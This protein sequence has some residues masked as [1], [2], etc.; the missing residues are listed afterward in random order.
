MRLFV[1]VNLPA[2]ERERVQH[3]TS[4]LRESTLPVQWVAPDAYHLTLKFLGEVV[5]QRASEVGR[6]VSEAATY[7]QSFPLRLRAAGAFPSVR[8]PSV[9]WI[10]VERSESLAA[11]QQSVERTLAPLGFQADA[12]L[13]SPHLTLGR[14]RRSAPPAALQ[15]AESLL[16]DVAYDS[17]ITVET[18]DLMRSHLSSRG[19]RYECLRAAALRP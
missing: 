14:T 15:Q 12:R 7:L 8:R 17:T 4:A 5:D 6:A 2:A 1:A 19:A 11:L 18:L 9:W 16:H 3:A 13:F 10:G